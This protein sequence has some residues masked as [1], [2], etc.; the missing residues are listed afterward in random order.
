MAGPLGRIHPDYTKT[1]M[2]KLINTTDDPKFKMRLEE[3]LKW[4]N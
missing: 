2:R 4:M 1:E 3:I